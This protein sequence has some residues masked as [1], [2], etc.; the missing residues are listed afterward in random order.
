[1][2]KVVSAVLAATMLASVSALPT[3]ASASNDYELTCTTLTTSFTTD[4]GIIIPAGAVAI[5]AMV[6]DN[7]GF[8]ANTITL[9]TGSDCT[10][11][12]DAA[13]IPIVE[14]GSVLNNAMIGMAVNEGAVCVTA[15]SAQ[16]CTNDGEL[17]T[18]Y[19]MPDDGFNADE[20]V[21]SEVQPETEQE[22]SNVG[23]I[24]PGAYGINRYFDPDT[25]TIYIRRGD[26]NDNNKV[27]SLDATAIMVA[28]DNEV[29]KYDT[30]PSAI[31]ARFP[32]IYVWY[33]ADANGDGIV[34]DI[35]SS[36][37]QLSDARTILMYAAAVGVNQPYTGYGC[38]TVG[39]WYNTSTGLQQNPFV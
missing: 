30:T 9:D 17:F 7:A 5:S 29:N 19:V 37:P 15:A 21:I 20:V 13:G 24:A 34:S 18:L 6:E 38:D 4:E 36:V 22:P 2:K 31:Q 23:M 8:N 39:K 33:Q 12:T 14:T 28:Y 11:I 35:D 25:G 26:V 27:N 1:M 10:V 16:P 3:S 32:L